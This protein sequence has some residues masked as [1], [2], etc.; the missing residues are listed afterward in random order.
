MTSDTRSCKTWN[1]APGYE[2][3]NKVN[4]ASCNDWT[5]NGGND[6]EKAKKENEYEYWA[7]VMSSNKP[8]YLG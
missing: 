2:E 4:C 6:I 8:A 7:K 5:G 1:V 3:W